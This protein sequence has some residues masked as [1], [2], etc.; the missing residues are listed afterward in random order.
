LIKAD[1]TGL[2]F[3]MS[4]LQKLEREAD[5]SMARMIRGVTIQAARSAALRTPPGKTKRGAMPAKM[6]DKHVRRPVRPMTKDKASGKIYWSNNK[7][8]I[9]VTTKNIPNKVKQAKGIKRVKKGI[10]FWYKQENRWALSPISPVTGKSQLKAGRR[11]PAAGAAKSGWLHASRAAGE[12]IAPTPHV[13]S[14][15][16]TGRITRSRGLLLNKVSYGP[17][18]ASHIPKIAE[19]MAWKWLLGNLWATERKKLRNLKL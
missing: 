17:K 11:I 19:Q 8:E 18:I 6:P 10:K 4:N 2:E 16:G 1:I 14:V 3:T 15:L 7:G 13:K 9:F 5:L 12:Y